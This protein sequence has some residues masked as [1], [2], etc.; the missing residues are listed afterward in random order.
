MTDTFSLKQVRDVLRSLALQENDFAADDAVVNRIADL[1]KAIDALDN[2]KE[3]W[4]GQW[5]SEEHYKAA[6]LFAAAKT[7]WRREQE[8]KAT[9]N[10][11]QMRAQIVARFNAWVKQI[12]DRL[13]TYEASSRGAAT[14]TQWRAE[15]A[16]F[17]Q[18]P[19]NNP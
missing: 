18:D 19:V 2:G 10:D 8:S 13:T 1:K 16:R 6:V 14:V 17:K 3:P 9:A 5:L 4:L 15:L 12:Q 11:R 7:N